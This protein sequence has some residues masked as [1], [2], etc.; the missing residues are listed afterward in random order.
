[1]E[2]AAAVT[3]L[4]DGDGHFVNLKVSDGYLPSP[5]ANQ[6]LASFLGSLLHRDEMSR[7]NVYVATPS[8]MPELCGAGSAACYYPAADKMFIVGESEFGGFP[9][10]FVVA[11]EYGHHVADHR[12]NNPW[13]AMDWGTKR[14]AT[15]E[16]VCPKVTSG[17]Y[18]PGNEG[19]HYWE[20]PGEAFAEA[21]AKSDSRYRAMP[22]DWNANLEP[23]ATSYE[24]IRQDVLNPWKGNSTSEFS[25]NLSRGRSVTRSFETPL[26]GALTLKLSGPRNTDF[27]LSLRSRNGRVLK[28]SKGRNSRET[29]RFTVCGQSKLKFTV[30]SYYGSGNAQVSL[31]KP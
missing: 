30:R 15:Y 25:A 14:W 27:D 28:Q 12:G 2:K 29:V 11:H 8:E 5:A 22:W 18:F 13:R 1:M 20:N 4:P 24:S 16:G 26:D 6:A 7:L 3:R 23:N 9:T 17:L 19:N 31:S 21:F 10:N